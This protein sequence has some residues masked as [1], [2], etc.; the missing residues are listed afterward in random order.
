MSWLDEA[1]FGKRSKKQVKRETL[2][3]NVRKGRAAEEQFVMQQRL[4]GREVERTGRG[5]DFRVRE[6][7]PLTGKTTRT[8]TREIKS[9]ETAPMSELQKKKR[10][11]KVV[12]EPLFY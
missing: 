3:E 1:L 6:R 4:M 7:D 12:V 9:S 10:T 11:K 8:Y 5:S 2:A